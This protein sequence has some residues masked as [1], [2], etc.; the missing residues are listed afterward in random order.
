MVRNT[1][2]AAIILLPERLLGERTEKVGHLCMQSTDGKTCFLL[3]ALH[4]VGNWQL[5]SSE[6]DLLIL[7]L[8][9]SNQ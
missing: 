1:C 6:T 8:F 9:F 7:M 5:G 4:R 2:S 3:N